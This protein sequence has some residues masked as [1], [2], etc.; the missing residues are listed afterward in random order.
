MQCSGVQP[1]SPQVLGN[2]LLMNSNLFPDIKFYYTNI[3]FITSAISFEE[4]LLL[5][6]ASKR[7]HTKLP[8]LL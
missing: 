5:Q 2:L 1:V 6:L 7:M 3:P 8:F 4:T